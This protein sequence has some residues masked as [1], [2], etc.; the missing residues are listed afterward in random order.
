[1]VNLKKNKIQDVMLTLNKVLMKCAFGDLKD[2]SQDVTKPKFQI[3]SE[4]PPRPRISS[5]EKRLN[6]SS[7]NNL[8]NFERKFVPIKTLGSM[9]STSRL[10]NTPEKN[11]PLR[12]THTDRNHPRLSPP[13]P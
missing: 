3:P 5:T 13:K 6:K 11:H 1:M 12:D 8:F 9:G 10:H 2:L 4:L 7:D